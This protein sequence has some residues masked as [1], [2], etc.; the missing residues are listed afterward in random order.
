[1]LSAHVARLTTLYVLISLIVPCPLLAVQDTS[2]TRPRRVS[3]ERAVPVEVE[4]SPV[5]VRH[6]KTLPERGPAVVISQSSRSEPVIRVGLLTNARAVNISTNGR[7]VSISGNSEP[8]LMQSARVRVESRFLAPLPPA[9]EGDEYRIEFPPSQTRNSAEL[10]AKEVKEITGTTEIVQDRNSNSWKV[11]TVARYSRDDAE[12]V[13]EKLEEEGY[14]ATVLTPQASTVQLVSTVHVPTRELVVHSASDASPVLNARVPV[15]FTSDNEQLTPV[16][17]NEKAY[18]GRIEV[19]ANPKGALTVVNVVNLEEYVRGVVPNELSPGGYPALDALKAQAIAARTYALRNL[20]QFSAQGFDIL[21]T[22]RSQVY[23]GLSTEHPL[24]TR[25]VDETRGVVAMYNGQPINALYTSTCGGRTEHAEN[26]FGGKV[27][28]YLRGTE[29]SLH[30]EPVVQSEIRSSRE[31]FAIRELEHSTS[32][33]DIAL[34]SVHGF[35]LPANISDEWLSSPITTDEARE[36]ISSVGRI[37][38]R[39]PA[40]ASSEITRIS[41]FA[42]ALAVALDGES[43]GDVLLTDSDIKYLLS[44]RDA[45]SVPSQNRPDVALLLRDGHITLYPDGTL[46]PSAAMTRARAL[47]MTA[48]LLESRGLLSLQK[49]TGRS[50]NTSIIQV[51]AGQRGP[52]R[53][54]TLSPLAFLFR[55]FGPNYIPVKSLNV[56][57]GEPL[58]YHLDT[59]GQID[60]LEARPA[61]GG[62]ASDRVSPFSHW[63]TQK[64]P[65]ELMARLGSRIRG[66]GTIVDMKVVRRGI[67]RRVLDLEVMGTNG[68][69]HIT[70]GRIRS[71]LGFKEQLFTIERRMDETGRVQSFL[72]K[73]RGWGHGVGMCQVGAYG[74]AKAGLTYDRIL[75]TYYSNITLTKIY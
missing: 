16:K 37:S 36:V 26:I 50:G 9:L 58:T 25:A 38:R 42:S 40:P 5:E 20:G 48:S 64:T 55:V 65:S 70:G 61:N 66:I 56:M 39:T 57:G 43:Q 29:C 47:R 73:G 52:D 3:A 4:R 71:V 12:D 51:R 35:R 63:T 11:R 19:F 23:G 34:L 75:K 74:M 59:R 8:V 53:S 46:R 60:Y 30:E 10:L 41:G 69:A 6:S 33:R 49:A 67:S 45:E 24:A 1:M 31:P 62:A 27:V 18:R 72:F 44:F 14:T 22:T 28:S 15:T 32:A 13:R 7:L 68:S 54:I 2:G 21:P 17:L